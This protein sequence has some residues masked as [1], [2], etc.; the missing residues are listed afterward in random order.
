MRLKKF[1][2]QITVEWI[3]NV[4]SKSGVSDKIKSVHKIK[5][6]HFLIKSKHPHSKEWEAFEESVFET[7]EKAGW[8]GKRNKYVH[9]VVED[10]ND[11]EL[12][13]ISAIS[14]EPADTSRSMRG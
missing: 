13:E 3:E 9:I 6:D 7:L 12:P 5:D 10:D 14:I 8:N 4:L 11:I 1:L 2:K